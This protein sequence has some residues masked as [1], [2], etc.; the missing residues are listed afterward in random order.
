MTFVKERNIFTG[1]VALLAVIVFGVSW[2]TAA[3]FDPTWVFGAN[4][5]S[6]LGVSDVRSAHMSFN[7]GC[8][9]A[10]ILFVWFGI[11]LL[12]SGKRDLKRIAG[13]LAVVSGVAMSLIGIF[14]EG[15]PLHLPLALAAFGVGFLTLIV[16]AVMDWKDGLRTLASFTPI[17]LV[18]TVI[19]YIVLEMDI[20]EMEC[21][22]VGLQGVETMAAL[23][24]LVLFALQGMKFLYN[25]ALARA[26]NGKGIADRHRLAYGFIALIGAVAFLI[27]WLFSVLSVPSWTLGE[28]M[29]SELAMVDGAVT[30]LS[31]AFI[32]GGVFTALYGIGTG[33]MRHAY[34][35]NIS[36]SFITVLGV[37][38]ILVGLAFFAGAEV[39]SVYGY[40]LIVLAMAALTCIAAA[41]WQ[42]KKMITAAFYLMLL[43]CGVPALLFF[44]YALISAVTALMFPVVL[45]VEGVRLVVE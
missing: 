37:F 13:V 10:G 12:I 41:D 25:G 3:M 39:D 5:L 19:T 33:M 31:I 42:D 11:G 18:L 43:V 1:M 2:Y 24:L 14:V 20:V 23:V 45:I 21:A 27:F 32:A 36:G 6:D 16:L 30:Y 8:L 9:L 17:G 15:D 38:M 29:I 22:L 7:M 35:R 28:D 34:V 4:Y 40:L 26:S 44:E